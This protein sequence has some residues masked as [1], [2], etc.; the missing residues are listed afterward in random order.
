MLPSALMRTPTRVGL[1]DFGQTT[2]M[3][4]TSRRMAYSTSEMKAGRWPGMLSQSLIGKTLGVIGTGNIGCQLIALARSV[5]MHVIAWTFNPTQ[6]KA[7]EFGF[8]Y[9]ELDELLKKSDVVSVNVKLTDDSREMIGAAQFAMMK[10]GS[11]FINTARAAVVDTDAM[12]DSLNSGHLM[13]AGVDVYDAE[14]TTGDSPLLQCDQVVLTP[15]AADQVSEAIDALNLG[16]VEN[17]VNHFAGR[18]SNNVT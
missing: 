14:P 3:F 17:V 7:D 4:A 2:A 1:F 5:G 9:C 6:Q 12:V 18:P 8:Q 15:H 13:G 10:P 16:A 11:I